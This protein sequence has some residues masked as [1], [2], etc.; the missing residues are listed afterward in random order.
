MFVFPAQLT[1]KVAMIHRSKGSR[2]RVPVAVIPCVTREQAQAVVKVAHISQP[3]LV[4]EIATTLRREWG[5][6]KQKGRIR[7]YIME[8]YAILDSLG[9]GRGTQ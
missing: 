1:G 5:K 9:L 2:F 7:N 8:A 4:V 6:S 3:E